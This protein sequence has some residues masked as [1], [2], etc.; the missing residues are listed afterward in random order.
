[1]IYESYYWKNELYKNYK[2]LVNF[3]NLKRIK[4]ES[5]GNMEKAIMMSAYIIRK[6]NDAEKIPFTFII[7]SIKLRRYKANNRVIDHM[8]FHR[9]NENYQLNNGIIEKCKW[10]YI[11]NQLIH[12]FTFSPIFDKNKFCG[13]LFNSDFSK[14][15][16]LYYLNIKDIIKIILKISEGSIVEAHYERECKIDHDG[17][18]VYGNIH[19]IKAKYTYPIN[20][21]LNTIV[22]KSMKGIIY[23]RDK[24]KRY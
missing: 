7:E 17:Q 12:S 18:K 19:L 8:N 20:F 15:K 3:R 16:Y 10:N 5:F 11:F 2:C 22:E 6:L 9:I 23:K 14:N 24:K 13:I 4:N 21:N 1:M